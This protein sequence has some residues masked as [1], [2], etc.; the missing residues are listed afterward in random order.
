MVVSLLI[1]AAVSGLFL[2]VTNPSVPLSPPQI[3]EITLPV[4][5]R[6]IDIRFD[7]PSTLT[8]W[9]EHVFNKK[10]HYKIEAD[11]RGDTALHA[12]SRDG[13]SVIFKII[14]VPIRSRPILS[15]EWRA[16]KFPEGKK[17]QNLGAYGE[18]DFAI[19][20]C[21]VFGNNP[22]ALNILQYV[23]DDHFPI[24]TYGKSPYSG[25]VRMLVVRSGASQSPTWAL[26]TRDLVKDYELAFGKPP[27]GNLR[28]LS[29]ISNSD[30][31][32]TE[33]E[34]YVRRIWV[35]KLILETDAHQWRLNFFLR[36]KRLEQ[37][38][39]SFLDHLNLHNIKLRRF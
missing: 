12:S 36:T 7:R 25:N 17:H 3:G 10:S 11:E 30:D 20:L 18:N 1:I 6:S 23:W 27:S 38:L 5:S 35:E 4:L 26:E 37:R 22:F 32:H 13:F 31:T 34:A 29:I 19:R 15:W 28:A 8:E 21:A 2:I 39:K 14:D 33:S 16:V 9:H 24:G